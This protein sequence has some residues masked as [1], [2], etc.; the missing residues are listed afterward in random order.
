M[1]NKILRG[2]LLSSLLA[3]ALGGTPAVG[4]A[5]S[6]ELTVEAR[7]LGGAVGYARSVAERTLLGVELGAGLPKLDLTVHPG[8]DSAP[9]NVEFE[10]YLHLAVFFRLRPSPRTDVDA[11]VR[12]GVAD[13]YECT[14]SDCWPASSVGAYVQPMWGGGRFKVGARVVAA[15]VGESPEGEPESSTFALGISPLLVRLSIPW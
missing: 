4:V 6:R 5:Q 1:R 8:S 3:G 11:G 9:G 13:L 2:I 15:L 7:L 10:E 14:A 12:A